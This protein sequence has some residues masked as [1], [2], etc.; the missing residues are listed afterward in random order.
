M[1]LYLVR[2]AP[3]VASGVCYG[4]CDVP[5][6]LDPEDAAQ[7]VID[8]W[9]SLG[10][11]GAPELWSSPWARTRELAEVL[12]RRWDTELFID[13]R[14]SELAFGEWEGRRFTDIELCDRDRFEDWM[15]EFAVR[16]P[17]GGETIAELR[18]RFVAWERE[19]RRAI[20]AVPTSLLAITHAGLHSHCPRPRAGRDL[21]RRRC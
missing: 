14:L 3:V 9:E 17:P 11:A 6:A 18:D 16:A 15:R 2:H 13:A 5:V 19:R 20:R 7:M 8:R 1:I 21:H 10:H 4:Q 12:A